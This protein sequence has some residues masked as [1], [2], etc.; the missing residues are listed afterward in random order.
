[1]RRWGVSEGSFS[2][3]YG[4]AGVADGSMDA[5][6]LGAALLGLGELFATAAKDLD[7]D[8]PSP[9]LRVSSTSPGSFEIH[10]LLTQQGFMDRVVHL[11]SGAGSAAT[12]NLLGI[13]TGA[14]GVIAF[15][16]AKRRGA[17]R[18]EDDGSA[19]VEVAGSKVTFSSDVVRLAS[20]AEIRR[21]T[22]TIFGPLRKESVES[23]TFRRDG[24]DALEVTAAD[25][26]AF[27]GETTNTPNSAPTESDVWLT[28]TRVS[29]RPDNKWS[30]TDGDASFSARITD[31]TF[32]S[33]V[34]AGETFGV[35]DQVHCRLRRIP[36]HSPDGVR[37]EYEIIRV[38]D[39]IRQSRTEMMQLFDT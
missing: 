35:R 22:R 23:V 6:E 8:S 14:G 4:G 17:T 20:N 39:H 38:H 26:S 24:L 3:V 2:V 33:K 9:H 30:F 28:P 5:A 34:A 21:S 13:V 12:S 7:P 36:I 37:A 31:R 19:T 29:F 16:I 11:L 10:L 18:V 27:D 15:L 1:M 25:L 32:L